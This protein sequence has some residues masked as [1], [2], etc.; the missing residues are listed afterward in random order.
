MEEAEVVLPV[1]SAVLSQTAG[2]V[3]S[4]S[5]DQAN[6]ITM[7]S[8]VGPP[9]EPITWWRLALMYQDAAN[10]PRGPIDLDLLL[11][12]APWRSEQALDDYVAAVEHG[13]TL[14]LPLAILA[15]PGSGSTPSALCERPHR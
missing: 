9:H 15:A 1:L 12:K 8:H 6:L 10:T 11:A 7:L 5:Q 4:I 3:R 13:W 2:R 14:S